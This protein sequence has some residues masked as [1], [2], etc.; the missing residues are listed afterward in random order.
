MPVT[1]FLPF[2]SFFPSSRHKVSTLGRGDS[3]D[4]LPRTLLLPSS[5]RVRPLHIPVPLFGSSTRSEF[6]RAGTSAVSQSFL[7]LTHPVVLSRFC[8][9][10]RQANTDCTQ[11][12]HATLAC[13]PSPSSPC[14][15]CL[16]LSLGPSGIGQMPDTSQELHCF[17]DPSMLYLISSHPCIRTHVSGA[18]ATAP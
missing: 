1:P 4:S 15:H 6:H 14:L 16:R 11:Q 8:I 10:T 2:P 3:G 9:N 17:R 7:Y 12:L 13:S 5:L 18:K